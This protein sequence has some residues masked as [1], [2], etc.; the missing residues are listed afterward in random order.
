M[1]NTFRIGDYTIDAFSESIFSADS[2][3]EYSPVILS[4]KQYEFECASNLNM[5]DISGTIHW[6]DGRYTMEYV[7]EIMMQAR[8]HK[9]KRINKKWLKRYGM[10]SEKIAMIADVMQFDQDEHCFH[11][12]LHNVKPKY[13]L[14]KRRK[15]EWSNYYG[16]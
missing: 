1:D 7:T 5:L 4:T 11:F 3:P 12:T 8:W 15:N 2:E 13:P 9:K 6:R 14:N 16:N 10:R